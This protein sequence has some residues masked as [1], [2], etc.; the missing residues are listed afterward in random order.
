M[1]LLP[2]S[3]GYLF[4]AISSIFFGFSGIFVETLSTYNIPTNLMG[5][6]RPLVAFIVFFIYLF[7]GKREYLKV[8]RKGLFYMGLL[9][10]I[11]QA[12]FNRLYFAAIEKTTIATAVVLLYTAPIFVIIIAR[13]LYKELFNL[14]K[15]IALVVSLTGCFLTATGGS[16]GVL[17]LNSI[18]LL[19]GLGTGFT[20]AFVPIISKNLAQRYHYLTIAC[21]TMGFGALFSFV[22]FD[23]RIIFVTNYNIKIWA[24]LIALGFFSNALAYLFYMKGMSCNIQSSKA[25]II[26]TVEVPVAALT[27]LIFFK[28]Y[29]FGIKLVGIILVILSVV[30]IEYGDKLLL[31]RDERVK[32]GS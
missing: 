7:I 15:V 5:F 6:F 18:G 2:S 20:F 24:N 21:Y 32:L 30:I 19:L 9:G 4:I 31:K 1:E 17:K 29:I 12:L 22:F 14:P 28:E 27:S 13:L 11:S 3:K 8:D 10:F 23:P 26:N 25:T 16:L